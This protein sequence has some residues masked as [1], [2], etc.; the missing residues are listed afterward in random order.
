M[1]LIT[2]SYP[3]PFIVLKMQKIIKTFAGSWYGAS[4]DNGPATS[5]QF[6]SVNGMAVDHSG[7]LYIADFNSAIRFINKAS[8]I[9]TTVVGII[10]VSGSSGDNGPATSATIYSPQGLNLDTTNNLLYIADTSNKKVRL[11]TL[12]SGII[13]TYAGTG[14]YGT[15]GDG[16]A[17]INA[18]L[19]YV[20]GVA[21]DPFGNVYIADNSNN[22]IRKV[23]V[24]GIIFSYAGTGIYGSSGDGGAATSATLSY[25]QGVACDRNGNVYFSD[26]GNRRI[27]KVDNAGIISTIA[28]DGVYSSG[29]V[30]GGSSALNAHL[31]YPTGV[32]VDVS[33][34]IYIVDGMIK[35]AIFRVEN[36][37]GE[38]NTYAGVGIW[39]SAGDGGPATLA[40]LSNPRSVAVDNNDGTV[41]I[42]DAFRV[43]EVISVQA[44]HQPS[45]QPT[46]QPTLS[47]SKP[48]NPTHAPT[49]F[50]P[51]A[52]PTHRPTEW[53]PYMVR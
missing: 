50:K 23:N 21:S 15:S 5:A 1:R 26:T 24:A 4:G 6:A 34:N 40:Y 52:E 46:E 30:V 13:T 33:G 41:Y 45:S 36:G 8:G 16:Y 2:F 39:G 51:T 27:R 38:I 10:G 43:R 14:D 20:T 12:S 3:F 19:S 49:T 22:K 17:A 35:Y 37:T 53:N 28:G 9:V 18:Q 47:P 11:V 44:T 7:N 25:P 32:A 48:T 31:A 42:G 29:L